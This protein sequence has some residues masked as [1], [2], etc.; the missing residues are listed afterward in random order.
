MTYYKDKVKF[1]TL[2][3]LYLGYR[4]KWYDVNSSTVPIPYFNPNEVSNHE[5]ALSY[6]E[7]K[8][9][10]QVYF[11][12]ILEHLR[13][14]NQFIMPHG[15]GTLKLIKFKSKYID[16]IAG[17]KALEE[18]KL[19]KG[20]FLRKKNYALDSYSFKLMWYRTNKHNVK[21][22]NKYLYQIWMPN[23]TFK[24]LY[25]WFKEDKSRIY[26]LSDN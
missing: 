20:T 3:D 21:F 23:P 11:N 25:Y 13:E 10:L 18:G 8:N 16:Y 26:K 15:L 4:H 24:K 7:W 1:I 19:E 12:T 9:Y 17:R 5:Y 14:G 6:K 22:R 2:K